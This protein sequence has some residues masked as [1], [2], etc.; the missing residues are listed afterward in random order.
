MKRAR[1]NVAHLNRHGALVVVGEVF[2]SKVGARGHLT[3]KLKDDH[4]GKETG[5]ALPCIMFFNDTRRLKFALE[6]GMRVVCTGEISVSQFAQVQFVVKNIE[7]VGA[8]AL[9]AAFQ[10]L[11]EKLARE[12]L[13]AVERKRALPF[14][15]RCV[16]V[17]TSAYGAAQH[18]VLERLRERMPRLHVIVRPTKVQGDEA[19]ADVAEAIRDLDKHGACDVILVV[20]GGGSLDDLWAFNTEPVVRAIVAARTPIVSGVGHESDIT[21]AD[22]AADK[23]ASTPTHAAELAVAVTATELQER[24]A[25]LERRLRDATNA[26]MERAHLQLTRVSQRL[27]ARRNLVDVQRARVAA[28]VARMERRH[29]AQIVSERRALLAR[30]LQRLEARHPS[31]AVNERRGRVTALLQRLEARHPSRVVHERRAL[32]AKLL[33]RLEARTPARAVE[34]RRARVAALA[35]RLRPPVDRRTAEA[36]RAF[37]V[38][39]ARLHALSPLAVL[40]R[41]YAVVTHDDGRVVARTSDVRDGDALHVRVSDGTIDVKVTK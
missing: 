27:S 30:V 31:R 21:L 36:K 23:R 14:L 25:R 15:P 32:V 4:R 6:Q 37:A 7:P 1:A 17:V 5:E 22:L 41:G 24:I 9:E 26:R 12:G 38:V 19:S 11:K 39:L 29:P 2:E 35:Q 18:D 10:Q 20:R 34:E 3:F 28:L 16:G 13:F 8:G 40:A 33:Q